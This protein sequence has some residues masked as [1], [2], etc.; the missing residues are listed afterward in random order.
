MISPGTIR[1]AALISKGVSPD[2]AM[3]QANAIDMTNSNRRAFLAINTAAVQEQPSTTVQ[4]PVKVSGASVPTANLST[5]NPFPKGIALG[6]I[7]NAMGTATQKNAKDLTTDEV[8]KVNKIAASVQNPIKQK[9]IQLGNPTAMLDVDKAQEGMA[10]LS[11]AQLSKLNLDLQSTLIQAKIDSLPTNI[12]RGGYVP[13]AFKNKDINKELL[14]QLDKINEDLTMPY[15]G[16]SK[17]HDKRLLSY[18]SLVN[19]FLNKNTDLESFQKSYQGIKKEIDYMIQQSE[20][21]KDYAD[22]KVNN[23]NASID[24]KS[25]NYGA[26]AIG[27]TRGKNN[28]TKLLGIVDD[29][30]KNRVQS[31]LA[32]EALTILDQNYETARKA[33]PQLT[34]QK[35]F[36]GVQKQYSSDKN[37]F[38]LGQLLVDNKRFGSYQDFIKAVNPNKYSDAYKGVADIDLRGITDSK[39]EDVNS[40]GL[41][42]SKIGA[43][44]NQTRD[45]VTGDYRLTDVKDDM[46]TAGLQFNQVLSEEIA[47]RTIDDIRKR[48]QLSLDYQKKKYTGKITKQEQ[49]DY[50]TNLGL[51]EKRI[52]Y[53]TAAES[54]INSLASYDKIKQNKDIID[55]AEDRLEFLDKQ[56]KWN[57]LKNADRQTTWYEDMALSMYTGRFFDTQTGAYWQEAGE[58]LWAKSVGMGKDVAKFTDQTILNQSLGIPRSSNYVD[59]NNFYNYMSNR[60]TVPEVI[61]QKASL[62][63]GETVT[64]TTAFYKDPDSWYKHRISFSGLGMMA[65]EVT[66]QV[67]AFAGA[68]RAVQSL[69]GSAV[70]AGLQSGVTASLFGSANAGRFASTLAKTGNTASAWGVTFRESNNFF[71]REVLADRL[72][73]AIG[74]TAVMYP[75]QYNRTF[76]R[77]ELQGVKDADPNL[78]YFDDFAG[79]VTGYDAIK[80]LGKRWT[81]SFEQYQNLYSGVLGGKLS[82]KTIGYLARNSADLFGKVGTFGGFYLSRGKEEGLEEVFSELANFTLDATTNYANYRKEKPATLTLESA[83]NAFLGGFAAPTAGGARQVQAYSENKKY[84]AMYDM[85]VNA[86]YYRNKVNAAF[87]AGEINQTTASNMLG[88]LEQLVTIADEYGVQNL[89]RNSKAP[90]FTSDL[91]N[92]PE[93]QFD[94]FKTI[95]KVKGIEERL[96]KENNTLTD[97]ERETLMAEAEEA[98]KRIDKYKRQSDMFS[99]LSQE[100]KNQIVQN[101]IDAKTHDA[102]FFATSEVL[103]ESIEK[104]DIELARAIKENKSKEHIQA[105]RDYK[106]SLT[107]VSIKRAE[108]K[109]QAIDN[110]TYNQASLA[111]LEDGQV[112]L[113]TS[114]IKSVEDAQNVIVQAM[115]DPESGMDIYFSITGQHTQE[116]ERLKADKESLVDNF[117]DFLEANE[118]SP[119]EVNPKQSDVTDSTTPRE[120]VKYKSINDLTDEQQNMF[121]DIADS[122]DGEIE[123]AEKQEA[124]YKDILDEIFFAAAGSGNMTLAQQESFA[125]EIMAKFAAVKSVGF[126]I[127]ENTGAELFDTAAFADYLATNKTKIDKKVKE[128][129]DLVAK[130]QEKNQ[131]ER[132]E[133]SLDNLTETPAEVVETPEAPVEP[134]VIVPELVESD[135]TPTFEANLERLDLLSNQENLEVIT[136]QVTGE[137][138]AVAEIPRE[139]TKVLN[140]LIAEVVK[141]PDLQG[142]QAMMAAIMQTL[143]KSNSEIKKTLDLME[144]DSKNL[145]IDSSETTHLFNLYQLAKTTEPTPTN[146]QEIETAVEE[147]GITP[148]PTQLEEA[149]ADIER[150]RQEEYAKIDAEYSE[151]IEAWEKKRKENIERTG[152]AG[153]TRALDALKGLVYNAK[154]KVD[155]LLNKE[156]D[157]LDN[158]EDKKEDIKNALDYILTAKYNGKPNRKRQSNAIGEKIAE[159]IATELA[160]KGLIQQNGKLFSDLEGN[161]IGV[162]WSVGKYF[163]KEFKEGFEAELAAL[164]QTSPVVEPVVIEE[165]KPVSKPKPSEDQQAQQENQ[166]KVLKTAP[167]FYPSSNSQIDVPFFD[168][169]DRIIQGLDKEI[170]D[171]KEVNTALVDLFTIIEEVLGPET[172]ESLERIFNEVT[173]PNV[174]PQRLKELRTEFAF[175]FP[176]GFLRNTNLRYI[177]DD[178]MVKGIAQTDVSE[179][180]KLKLDATDDELLPL[181]VGRIVSIKTEKGK[182]YPKA[183]VAN[184][185]GVLYYVIKGARADGKDL[186]ITLD[187]TKNTIEGLRYP[188]FGTRPLHFSDL[189]TPNFTVLDKDGKVQRYSNDGNRNPDGDKVLLFRLPTA[190]YKENPTPLQQ[191]FNDVRTRLVQGERVKVSTP[192]KGMSDFTGTMTVAQQDG[193]KRVVNTGYTY[194]FSADNLESNNVLPTEADVHIQKNQATTIADKIPTTQA[195]TVAAVEKMIA[196]SKQIPDPSKEGYKI[197]GKR[198]ERQSGF[199]KRVLGDNNINTEDSITNMELGA[200]V[201]NLLDIIGRDVLGGNKIKTL[202]EYIQEAERMGKSL[203]QGKGYSLF[204][205]EQQFKQLIDELTQVKEELNKQGWKLFTEG[206]IVHRE[207]TEK[208]KKETGYE[209]VAGAMDILAVDPEG[210]VHIIDF[211]NKKYRTQDKF[212]SSLYSSKGGFP[213]N[214]SKWSTQQTT[215]AILGEDFGLPVDS[216]SIL[217]FASEYTE[218]DGVITID[219]L[220]LATKKAEV[221]DKHKSPASS[222]LIRLSFDPKIIKQINIRTN[223]KVKDSK[224]TTTNSVEKLQ[225]NLP[226]ISNETAQ[227]TFDVLNLLGIETNDLGFIVPEEGTISPDAINPPPCQ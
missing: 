95:L 80:K 225:E 78:K 62:A 86:D 207:F 173:N 63:A 19:G 54:T 208:E 103:A 122:L 172:L 138:I 59:R 196:E 45:R 168:I 70:K 185:N 14:T 200:G 97:K 161:N 117:L 211:K 169:Q 137:V 180:G 56:V 142:S 107:H 125:D 51:L 91:V 149:K 164:E 39:Q 221:L 166:T 143:G 49:D 156:L 146:V 77:L 159:R 57:N 202:A 150:R 126:K 85:M 9:S 226:E 34:Q 64:S 47:Q 176:S 50:E 106:D 100:E 3:A 120:R 15:L 124:K 32:K 183:S 223:L 222:N 190:K 177:F 135:I 76:E 160:N 89:K 96:A 72:P 182:V 68:G 195:T 33:N 12:S 209:G 16:A 4:S 115:L 82:E 28:A 110:G 58:R 60:L 162:A 178:I 212:T 179:K 111:A 10:K 187:R 26:G 35:F 116:L 112:S 197:N 136:N 151:K 75:E 215:Y 24:V 53:G 201:G 88:N 36:E 90:Q 133:V 224:E 154:E 44:G 217:A 61:D 141:N 153:D 167:L 23:P 139:R 92:S 129:Q 134:E 11:P 29:I 30:Y 113:D 108:L 218:E 31:L 158:I 27:Y 140:D 43:A 118:S 206:L 205:T 87:K 8:A 71:L 123:R 170:S 48:E 184:K 114:S 214:V 181:N 213:S 132:E 127:N 83:L 192:V 5:M 128:F 188:V 81:G 6:N 84:G 65:A 193:T 130:E 18:Q 175:L 37:A 121:E 17:D 165:A 105:I 22:R 145:P 66:P 109:Q 203:R 155:V 204:F 210:R 189:N 1:A 174:T 144:K 20:E 94:Y 93:K 148:E 199:V 40:Y 73:S 104:T 131:V 7:T 102:K 171:K 220:T 21:Y 67:L 147:L 119:N 69:A 227:N 41:Q 163:A 219:G 79:K 52:N 13:D 157:E 194:E 98:S 2:V 46:I 101:T 55:F 25:F 38:N 42:L 198:Y 99:N 74:M 152:L 216:I 186:W 191:A